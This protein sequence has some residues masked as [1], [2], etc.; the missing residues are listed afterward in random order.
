MVDSTNIP[1]K[2]TWANYL[3]RKRRYRVRWVGK[4]TIRAL[5]QFMRKQSAFADAPVMDGKSFP[6]VAP[7][8]ENWTQIHGEILEILKHREAIPLF[9][10]IS[11]EQRN[12]S[13][14]DNW[15]TYILFGFGKKLLKNSAQA[16]VTT[17][18]LE[19]VPNLQSAWFS[20]LSPNYHI[21]AHRGVTT[22]ILR[23]HLGLVIP[24]DAEKC[25]MRVDD[26]ICVWRQGELFVFDDTY[27]HEVWNETEDERVVLIFDFDRPMR[28]WGR[29]INK[30]FL[31][32]LKLTAYYQEP[33]K[34][35]QSYEDRF[36]RMVRRGEDNLEK[37]SGH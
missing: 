1:Q 7:F 12:I 20:I 4:H 15:R 14:G 8:S 34:K 5:S 25:R 35:M 21:P 33:R 13:K 28:F 6:W 27:D 30:I 2:E 11:D 17:Q 29:V 3:G 37:M 19:K 22:G 26:Q 23:A 9:H 10:E 18:L 24:K 31:Q 32:A 16:P 36:E